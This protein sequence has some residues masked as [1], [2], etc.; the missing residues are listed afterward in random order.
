MPGIRNTLGLRSIVLCLGALCLVLFCGSGVAAQEGL[1]PVQ[2]PP[3]SLP[4]S[5]GGH[6]Q[7]VAD[8]QG[9]MD[10]NAVREVP[11]SHW[12]A[13][14]SE[15]PNFGFTDTTYWFRASFTQGSEEQ[16]WLL[17]LAYPLLDYVDLWVFGEEGLVEHY[18]TGDRY[19]FS[20]RPIRFRNFLF[21]LSFPEGE[22]LQ[23]YVRLD[24]SSAIQMPMSLT[25]K[26]RLFQTEQR[27][28]T[29]HAMF[30]GIIL[31]MALYNLFIMFST[32]DKAYLLYVLFVLAIGGFQ[33]SLH[34]FAYQFLWPETPWMQDKFTGLFVALASL[35][36]AWFTLVFL[37]ARGYSRRL[38][39]V[40][41]GITIL[42]GVLSLLAPFVPYQFTIRLS[43]A[44]AFI[45]VI[46]CQITGLYIWYRGYKPA[47]YYSIAFA[48]VL[49]G[50]AL[51]IL[52]KF[53]LIP[54]NPVTE[55]GQ[56]I[57][58]LALLVLLS[59]A[60]AFRIKVLR[61]E[62]EEAQLEAT[63]RLE[64]RVR[65]RTLELED[66]NT[67]LQQLSSLDPLT[68]TFNRRY[69]SDQLQAEWKRAI[70]EKQPISLIMLDIDHF[71]SFNDQYGHQAGDE[72]L[73][74]LVRHLL[75]CIYRTSDVVVRYGGEE[76]AIVLP[77]TDGGGA[78]VIASRIKSTLKKHAFPMEGQTIPVTVSQGLATMTPST[79]DAPDSLIRRADE[80][81]Y[82]A[83]GQGRD[84][85]VRYETMIDQS[86]DQP[87]VDAS[88]RSNP[89]R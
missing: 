19:E 56:Q 81:L 37:N 66:A 14:A 15:T 23:V 20:Q 18:Q 61:D 64:H 22:T 3:E 54:M 70:R 33:A 47:V 69:F 9:R 57:G 28:L 43:A 63:T 6:F 40:L 31:V 80:A 71:K 52:N 51:M 35:F 36:G 88:S 26:E 34:G 86:P 10:I 24:S 11:D 17:E 85:F 30:F 38:S 72:C 21:P 79:S 87:D 65:E 76:F 53:G 13:V 49:G 41:L 8:P 12:R 78:E 67:K 1:E 60:L 7:Y 46:V 62:T 44:L 73:R 82:E 58:S 42:G 45:C 27:M 74:F 89:R 68:G 29:G 2:L 32:R 75:G 55:N 5:V 77:N 48:T 83:K 4:Y 50:T 39:K 16:E 84:R 25:T 59:F